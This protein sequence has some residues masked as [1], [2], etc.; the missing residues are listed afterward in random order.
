MQSNSGP[1]L[2]KNFRVIEM[3]DLEDVS[4]SITDTRIGSGLTAC[5]IARARLAGSPDC[6]NEQAISELR[7]LYR[8]KKKITLKMP[9]PTNTENTKRLN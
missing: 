7:V 1:Y 6:D 5:T 2:R 8:D 4:V 3:C 9:D